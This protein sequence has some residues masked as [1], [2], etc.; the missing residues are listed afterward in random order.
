[1]YVAEH[2]SGTGE[3][4]V[5]LHGGNVAGWTWADQVAHLRTHTLVPDL[6][7]FGA[8]SGEEWHSLADTAAQIADVIESRAAGGRAHVVGMSLGA[9]VGLHLLAQRPDVVRSAL[10]TGAPGGGVGHVTR[11]AAR[12]Q[13]AL[14]NR[15]WFWEAMARAFRLPDAEARRMFVDG[16]MDIRQETA[17]R[18]M[19]ELF[20]GA[21]PQGLDAA[22]VPVLLLAGAR[23]PR[24]IARSNV[25]VARVL[26]R[27]EVRTVPRM[28]HAWSAEDPELFNRV[29][30]TWL[31]G[32]R[33]DPA[34]TAA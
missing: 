6:P 28:H 17:K 20:A 19:A 24:E 1:M 26:P 15:R 16:G 29:M 32:A 25:A 23:E 13:V 5:L 2:R 10:L 12:V 34:L 11:A 3:T 21:L 33:V 22:D 4:V 7:G 31:D 27:A 30:Q 9:V 18:M 14:W 8:S